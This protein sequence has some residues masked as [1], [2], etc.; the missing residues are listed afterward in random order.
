MGMRA[1]WRGVWLG[2]GF[3]V[4]GA[5]VIVLWH[6]DFAGW[7]FIALGAAIITGSVM[8]FYCTVKY[9]LIIG[10]FVFIAG[11]SSWPVVSEII[12]KP[13]S[14]DNTV[15][16]DC[17]WNDVPHNREDRELYIIDFQQRP[18]LT[19]PQGQQVGGI[20]SVRSGSNREPIQALP[21]IWYRCD[22]TNFGAK[23]VTV[24]VNF[25]IEILDTVKTENGDKSGNVLYQGYSAA[26]PLI[27]G[28][29]AN[30]SD[31]F[32]IENSSDV[33]VGVLYPSRA[34][35]QVMGEN[36]I[37]TIKLIPTNDRQGGF[38]IFHPNKS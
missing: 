13:E 37:Q 27:L 22:A 5:G 33:Y 26:V 28:I 4:L 24:W 23:P 1:E 3:G 6:T 19:Y 11:L 21:G 16:I 36:K 8:H 9:S 15:R 31:Y 2:V 29:N 38:V 30:N 17:H 25:P 10:L 12:T 7:F 32:Y 14:Y 20:S 35:L 18:V 34:R